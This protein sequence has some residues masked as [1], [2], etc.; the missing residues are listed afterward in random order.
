MNP[1]KLPEKIPEKPAKRWNK[2]SKLSIDRRSVAKRMRQ[3]EKKTTTHAH[4]F[5]VQRIESLRS[6]REHIIAW[7]LT[8]AVVLLAILGQ[9]FL[10]SNQDFVRASVAGGT[11][12]EGVVGEIR[13]LNPLFASNAAEIAASKLMF[14]SLYTYD[15]TGALTN[16]LASSMRITDNG[17]KYTI[18]LRKDAEWHDGAPV[19]ARD[20]V[21]TIETIKNP[22][23]AVSSSLRNNWR[24]IQ[25][26]QVDDHSV[27]FTLPPYVSFPHALTFPIIP[28]HLLADVPAAVLRENSFSQAPV[29]SGPFQ[30]RMLQNSELT[31]SERVVHMSSNDRYYRGKPMI[32]RFELH[33]YQNAERLQTALRGDALTAA[34]N[35]VGEPDEESVASRYDRRTF[36]I[37]NGVYALTNTTR[38]LFADKGVRQ[39]V[40]ASLD[41]ASIRDAAGDNVQPLHLPFIATQIDSDKLPGVPKTDFAAARKSLKAAG[42]TEQRDS[43]TKKDETLS[44]TITTTKNLQYERVANEIAEQLRKMKFQV[45][46]T[47]IDDRLPNSNFVGDVLQRRNYEMLVYELQIG[48]DPDVYAYWH[49]SQLGNAGY[50]FT[51]YKNAISD[52]ALVS[53]RDQV[54][55]RLR[56]EKYVAFARQWLSDVPAIGL[57]QQVFV[58]MQKPNAATLADEATIVSP[59]DRFG[60]V[61]SWTVDR[62]DV[63]KTP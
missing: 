27:E 18:D 62:E 61:H 30:F 59:S 14:S 10:A 31:V 3:A 35:A 40:R 28:H 39:A 2:F 25:I 41:V 23:S 8:V 12:A 44:F 47:V 46:V 13:S 51:N 37:N 33:T 52:A 45:A 58:Y 57:Y 15:E 32:S 21:Y 63:Y 29:G 9:S 42:W 49:S 55:D 38:G 1:E 22:D 17:A 54:S 60:R 5:I 20:V 48:A 24:D 53:A 6:S 16:D 4:R 19:D 36:P 50:N 7:F 34:V 26:A 56:S 43:W 11:Y